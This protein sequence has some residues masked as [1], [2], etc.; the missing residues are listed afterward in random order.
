MT[1]SVMRSLA[2]AKD[3]C[4]DRPDLL[5]VIDEIEQNWR[6]KVAE[7]LR[8]TSGIETL[9]LKTTKQL[10]E[11]LTRVKKVFDKRKSVGKPYV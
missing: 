11:S 6:S 7:L 1:E 3:R 10:I 4:K 9:S 2:F 5:V 8:F